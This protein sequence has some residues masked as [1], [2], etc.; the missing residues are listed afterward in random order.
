MSDIF[1]YKIKP[2]HVLIAILLIGA[3]IRFWGL[4]SSELFHDEGF[5]AFR[6]IGNLDYI[7]NDD[8]T[9]PIQWFAES[10]LPWWTGLSFHDHPKLYFLIANLFFRMFGDS[11]FVA[12]LPSAISGVISIWLIYLLVRKLAGNRPDG[13]EW[14]ALLSAAALSVNHVHVWISRSVLMESI[15]ISAV[16]LNILLFLIFLEDRRKWIFF[17]LSLGACFLIKYTGLF[18]LPVYFLHILLFKKEFILERN[19]RLS[20]GIAF[21]VLS[22]VIVYNLYLYSSVGHFDL[23]LAF[24]FGQDTPEWRASLGKILDPFSDFGMNMA[25]MYSVPF[26]LISAFG[27]IFGA[28][29]LSSGGRNRLSA[30]SVLSVFSIIVMLIFAGSAYRFLSLLSP[31]LAILSVIML[32]EIWKFSGGKE[33]SRFLI[34][35]FLIY[36]MYFAIDGAFLTF[37]DFG[38]VRLDDYLEQVFDGRRSPAPPESSNP[39]LQKII[40]ENLL[41]YPPADTP[42]MV[43]YDENLALSAR[44]WLF[45]RRIYYHGISAVTTGQFKGFLRTRGAESLSGYKIYFIKAYPYTSLNQSLSVPD[46]AEFESFLTVGLNL[47]PAK[48]ITGYRNLPMFDVYEFTM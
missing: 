38:I 5:Y 15:Q 47:A 19:L 20:L 44:L 40:A 29:N 34:A 32:L 23:Q 30:F 37:P 2:G 26:L 45:T 9:T 24:I 25:A 13:G 3:V 27:F 22:P 18:L 48:R 46:A 28:Y 42:F 7:Q 1:G 14:I 17:G 10:T 12:R 31:F 11:L 16:L 36:E 39:H 4:G 43:I 41:K 33:I 35:G 21:L 8:Q 6:A